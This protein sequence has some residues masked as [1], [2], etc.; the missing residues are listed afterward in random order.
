MRLRGGAGP[1]FRQCAPHCPLHPS[2]P[3]G[4]PLLLAPSWAPRPQR[5]GAS[6]SPLRG[7]SHAA[8]RTGYRGLRPPRWGPGGGGPR[9]GLCALRWAREEGS[10]TP[11][12]RGLHREAEVHV[13]R[14]A[15]LAAAASGSLAGPDPLQRRSEHGRPSQVS[16]HPRSPHPTPAG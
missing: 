10:R 8:T 13:L 12:G 7:C 2:R 15:A 16:A 5:P 1:G 9:R 6:V 11:A 3:S 14:G 4:S